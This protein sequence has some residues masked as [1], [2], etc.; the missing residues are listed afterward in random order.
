MRAPSRSR[1]IAS[2]ILTTGITACGD[3][4]GSTD[5][6]GTTAV[7]AQAVTLDVATVSGDAAKEDVETFRVNR[8]AF[9]IAQATDFER[10]GRWD[11]CPFDSATGRFVCADR[12]RGPFT[13]T[14]SYAYADVNGVAQRAYSASSTASANFKWSLTGAITKD[15]WTGSMSRTR[16]V[17]L[18]GLLG[19]NSSVTVNGTGAG[20][21]ERTIFAADSTGTTR[22]YEMQSSL[23]IA[24]VVTPAIALPDAFPLSGTVTRTFTVT[25]TG[26]A[27]GAGTFTRTSVVT[28]NGT[29][30]VPL[31]VNGK[32]FTLN[33]VTGEVTP[34]ATA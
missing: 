9:G 32:A 2:L 14:R 34:V 20:Q 7:S 29:Q 11:P 19:A 8:G 24:N 5:P 18:S 4:S 23:A 10:F 3:S 26:T 21:R 15:R 16:D 31:V 27:N 28:F 33:L 17:T 6:V 25:R 13:N 22:T 12:T 30:F 1:V